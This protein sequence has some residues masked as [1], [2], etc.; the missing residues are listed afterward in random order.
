[1]KMTHFFLVYLIIYREIAVT[2]DLGSIFHGIK[3][4]WLLPISYILILFIQNFIA[5]LRS[6]GMK[7]EQTN[8]LSNL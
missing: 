8:S 3:D 5:Q 7:A 6:W 1:M 4:N 2:Y